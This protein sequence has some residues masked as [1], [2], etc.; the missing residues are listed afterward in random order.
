MS[1]LDPELQRLL[2]NSWKHPFLKGTKIRCFLLCASVISGIS[3]GFG[4][5][6]DLVLLVHVDF[7][8]HFIDLHKVNILLYGSFP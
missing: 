8:K 6:L 7:L 3:W 4:R 1:R 2:T 5:Y